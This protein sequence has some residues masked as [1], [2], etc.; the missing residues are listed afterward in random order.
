M[1]TGDLTGDVTGNITSGTPTF[2]AIDVNGGAIDGAVI[3]ANPGLINATTV[4]TTGN[5][6]IGGNLTVLYN[7]NSLLKHY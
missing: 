3:G 4:D 2:A 7:Y 6:T 5:V 1:A